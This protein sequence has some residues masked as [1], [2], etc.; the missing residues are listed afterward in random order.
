MREFRSGDD[1]VTGDSAVAALNLDS[2]IKYCTI[3][4]IQGLSLL[5][6]HFPFAMLTRTVVNHGRVVRRR[7]LPVDKVADQEQ[8]R[9]TVVVKL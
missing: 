8:V 7:F 6:N 9:S 3:V 4:H 1:A 2:S 5:E